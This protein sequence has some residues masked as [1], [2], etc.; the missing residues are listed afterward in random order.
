MIQGAMK[1]LISY[2][3]PAAPATRRY[4]AGDEP[5][6]RCEIGFAPGWFARRLDVDFSERYHVDPEYRCDAMTEMRGL[7]RSLFT[8]TSVGGIDRPETNQ[9]ILTGTFGCV[10]VAAIYG[11]PVVYAAAGWPKCEHKYLGDDQVDN[12][13]PPDLDSNAFFAALMGQVDWIAGRFGRTEG[14]INWQGVL[15]NAMR[16]RGQDLFTDLFD[17]PQRC[18]HLFDCICTTM[19]D[20]CRR[21]QRRQRAGGVDNNFFTVSNCLVNTIS[22]EQYR[23]FLLPCDKRIAAEFGCIGIHN[24]AWNA[25]PY[26]EHYASVEHLAYIDMSCHS[27]LAVAKGAIP[28]ARRAIMYTPMDAACKTMPEI[29]ADF[30]RIAEQYGPC[31]LVLADLEAGIPDGRIVDIIKLCDDIS[32]RYG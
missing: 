8:G 20:A 32:Q 15:N 16:L 13:R 29:T 1:Q 4:A 19:T 24:C 31:D 17:A 28:D 10:T 25:D 23:E 21:L 12:L 14:F 22:P 18:R 3:A 5:R 26:I 30:E 11:V 27:D 6:L 2:I 9:D 7:L